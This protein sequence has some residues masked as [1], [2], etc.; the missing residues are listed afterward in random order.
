MAGQ[1]KAEAPSAIRFKA[2]FD[3]VEVGRT[4]A[5][6]KGHVVEKPTQ[7]LLEAAGDRVEPV[8]APAADGE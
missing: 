5:Y 7:A 3:H 2:D 8:E 1:R 4:V 6:K